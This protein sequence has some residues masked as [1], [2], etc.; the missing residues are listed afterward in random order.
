MCMILFLPVKLSVHVLESPSQLADLLSLA[1]L[2]DRE[3]LTL[4]ACAIRDAGARKSLS[5]SMLVV[6]LVLSTPVML[7]LSS[8]IL[9]RLLTV[10]KGVVDY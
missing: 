9:F 5:Y 1:S 6:I 7:S 3:W 2:D 8:Q 10:A 4:G